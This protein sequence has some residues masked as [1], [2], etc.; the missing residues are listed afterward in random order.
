MPLA[1]ADDHVAAALRPLHSVDRTGEPHW[2]RPRTGS[3][4]AWWR[5]EPMRWDQFGLAGRS[6]PS[7]EKADPS[8][9]PAG[10]S[11]RLVALRGDALLRGGRLRAEEGVRG[12]TRCRATSP[13]CSGISARTRGRSR[14]SRR[15]TRGLWSRWT[16]TMK[17]RTFS[18]AGRGRVTN[19][20]SRRSSWTWRIRRRRRG[21]LV[22]S[23]RRS[24]EWKSGHGAVPGAA[25][26]PA[27]VVER[28]GVDVGRVA[29]GAGC[30]GRR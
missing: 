26:S 5:G 25:A 30:D 21:G 11:V 19:G 6:R 16:A 3:Q 12:E 13:P 7:R 1:V 2:R 4:D 9:G 8:A 15:G 28:A 20:T 23:V 27:G 17:R 29:A 10:G 18:T 14:A 24:G 22:G